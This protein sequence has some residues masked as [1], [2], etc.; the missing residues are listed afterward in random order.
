MTIDFTKT[1]L[2]EIYGCNCFNDAVMRERLPKSVYRE[3]KLVREGKCELDAD[4]AEVVAYAMKEWA[5]EKGATHFTHWFTP[6]TGLTAEKHDA[7]ISPTPDGKVILEFSGKELIKGEPDA[8]SFPNGGLRATFE[9]RGY[10]AWDV[11][12]A[13]FVRE[14]TFYIP[15][16]FISYNG[17]VLD[18]KVPLL[19]SMEAVNRQA[20]RIL[21]VFNTPGERVET[22]IGA[23]Q[24]YFLI[25]KDLADARPDIL[26][27]GRTVFGAPP[28]KGQEMED[29]YFGTIKE[30]ASAFMKEFNYELWKLGIAAKTQHKEVAPNQFEIAPIFDTASASFDKN[31]L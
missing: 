4:V 11:N 27:T 10:T 14:E 9:A 6:L 16:A 22:T 2:T 20:L 15:T 31:Q 3:V 1:S 17:E 5:I 28:A 23:E 13:A 25:E 21:K 26:L 12:S 8:S 24:E 30:R 18:K 19:R 29:H 7:F